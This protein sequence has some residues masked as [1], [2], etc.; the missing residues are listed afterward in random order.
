MYFLESNEDIILRRIYCKIDS[1]EPVNFDIKITCLDPF[2]D[3]CERILPSLNI[4]IIYFSLRTHCRELSN[5]RRGR[6]GRGEG[7]IPSTCIALV[8]D[9][10]RDKRYPVE[11]QQ[12]PPVAST[13]Q[14]NNQWFYMDVLLNRVGRK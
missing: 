13:R 11:R 1:K 5:P 6:V 12:S 7:R 8:I 3:P 14:I 4:S 9:D 2:D 10:A